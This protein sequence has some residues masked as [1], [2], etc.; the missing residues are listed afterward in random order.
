MRAQGY[1][2]PTQPPGY[3][4][5]PLIT[6]LYDLVVP[7]DVDADGVERCEERALGTD[8]GNA[9]SD[10]DGLSD[11][12]ELTLG[13]DPLDEDTD[14]DLLDDGMEDLLGTDPLDRDTDGDR[15]E[16]GQ[17]FLD[18]TDPTSGDSDGDGLLDGDELDFGTDPL[19]PDSDDDGLPDGLE[20]DVGTDPLLDDS[21][22]DGLLDGQDVEW[23]QTALAGL[24]PS[25]FLGPSQGTRRALQSLLDEVEALLLAG[26][27]AA[28]TRK[29][30]NL[31]RRL[32]GCGARPDT[33]D[34]IVT[35]GDQVD[36]RGLIDLL[37]GNL[38]P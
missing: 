9:D 2:F 11:G 18:G 21:D 22:G 36:V 7:P 24:P 26:D 13:T 29:L 32:D 4:G 15:I 28:A 17:E 34:W 23:I 5:T 27:T 6:A 35:C 30:V 38:A 16:D 10:E 19:N 8:P 33:N 3:A 31:R 12:V 20:I 1:V 25:A 37:R 14:G